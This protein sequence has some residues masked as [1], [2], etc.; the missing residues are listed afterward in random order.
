MA[1]RKQHEL[2]VQLNFTAGDLQ[3]SKKECTR[4]QELVD[5]LKTDD[6]KTNAAKEELD[7][8]L[9]ASQIYSWSLAD[10]YE[11]QRGAG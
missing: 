7:R 6:K 3:A 9:H 5:S 1:A 2:T 8:K 4:L 11:G 10:K